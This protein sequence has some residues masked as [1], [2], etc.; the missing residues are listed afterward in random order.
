MKKIYNYL[1]ENK[2]IT[3]LL[4]AVI[5]ITII[6]QVIKIGIQVGVKEQSV[7][8]IKGF[9]VIKIQ[10]STNG[11]VIR[12]DS[13]LTLILTDIIVL[14][15][16]MRFVVYQKERISKY[17]YVIMSL[18]LAGGLSNLIDKIFRG[19]ILNY[20][21]IIKLNHPLCF[22]LETMIII[23]AFVAFAFVTARVTNKTMKEVKKINDTIQNKILEKDIK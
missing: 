20:I 3:K 11:T 21:Q 18:L 17:V 16:I 2:N 1:K 10:N 22:N 14:A 9:A 15:M 6:L 7:D 4:I 23:I 12:T 13:R 19:G 8:I 5:V